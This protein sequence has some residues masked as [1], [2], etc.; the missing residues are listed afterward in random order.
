MNK[1]LDVKISIKEETKRRLDDD[2]EL[3]YLYDRDGKTISQNEF[4]T[5]I[6]VNTYK[7]RNRVKLYDKVRSIL[8]NDSRQFKYNSICER[9]NENRP[10]MTQELN[11]IASSIVSNFYSI[12]QTS[13]EDNVTIHVK[14]SY[15][16]KGQIGNIVRETSSISHTQALKTLIN[17]YLSYPPYIREEIFFYDIVSKIR[18]NINESQCCIITTMKKRE[19]SIKVYGLIVGKYENHLYLVGLNDDKPFSI[20][21]CSILNVIK[22]SHYTLSDEEKDNIKELLSNGAEWVN[23]DATTCKI[24][25]DEGGLSR[26][27]SIYANRPECISIDKDNMIYEFKGNIN[28]LFAYFAQFGEHA[29]VLDN[30]ELKRRLALR[31]KKAFN[32]YNEE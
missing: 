24:K 9:V 17:E 29:L 14:E 2:M 18:E 25:F 7:F 31:Y 11:E 10:N 13:S 16:N 21:L 28:H 5:T 8:C 6:I 4:L 22:G 30:A 20:K 27:R 1:Y 23:G 3:F 32:L 26:Y 15:R 19:L 12:D